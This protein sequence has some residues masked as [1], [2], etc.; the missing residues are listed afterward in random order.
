M[1][2]SSPPY[3]IFH[4]TKKERVNFEGE[5]NK[6]LERASFSKI[7]LESRPCDKQTIEYLIQLLDRFS[8]LL[9]IQS[10]IFK[11]IDDDELNFVVFAANSKYFSIYS[12]VC[13]L[14]IAVIKESKRN[15][16]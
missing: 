3:L 13:S 15:S 1:S 5:I 10:I 2:F 7:C 16:Q 4:D 12:S 11:I 6:I 9:D 8:L 14:E